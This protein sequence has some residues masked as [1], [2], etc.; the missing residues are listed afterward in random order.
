MQENRSSLDDALALMRDLRTRCAW[1]AAQTHESLR[2]YLLEEAHEVDDAIRAGDDALLREELGDLLLQVLFHSVVAEDRG[3]FSFPD[4]AR[5]FIAKM[6]RRHPHLYGEGERVPWEQQKARRRA[7]IVDGLPVDLPALHR[8]GIAKV[9]VFNP[10]PDA[11]A[12]AADQ[13]LFVLIP[14]KSVEDFAKNL[15]QIIHTR[16]RIKKLVADCFLPFQF[17]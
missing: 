13:K 6:Q 15:C 12:A 5:G 14:F 17:I 10:A 1:D 3:A 7:S 9:G 11:A 2:P 8:A 16:H 4:V